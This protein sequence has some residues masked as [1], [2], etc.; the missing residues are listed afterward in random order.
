MFSKVI[1]FV[2]LIFLT[3]FLFLG[4]VWAAIIIQ[5]SSYASEV[6][7]GSDFNVS[8]SASGLEPGASYYFKSRIGKTSSEMTKGETY[9]PSSSSWLGDSDVWTEFPAFAANSEG[10]S[11]ATL[12]ARA[13]SSAET[14]QN[15]LVVRLR[16]IGASSNA[17]DSDAITINLLSAPLP[18]E[19][20]TPLPTTTS[21]PEPTTTPIPVTKTPTPTSKK[22]TPAP[23]QVLLSVTP[24]VTSDELVVQ[25]A[26][27]STSL[28]PSPTPQTLGV[29]ASSDS[30]TKGKLVPIAL[31]GLGVILIGF[32]GT[33]ILIPY[34]KRYNKEHGEG[35]NFH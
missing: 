19:T 26:A 17:G 10:S 3:F 32:S 4:Q 15:N 23:S 35:P 21:L 28:E 12:K 22:P 9:N 11:S 16:K 18:S 14:G 30:S 13:K 2:W 25:E 5:I 1:F 7:I 24:T 29:S 33:F 20:P 8:I 31:I 6:T 27:V 34:L